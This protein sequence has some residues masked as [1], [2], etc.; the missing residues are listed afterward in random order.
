MKALDSSYCQHQV[1]F[2]YMQ[3]IDAYASCHTQLASYLKVAL[4]S[5][6]EQEALGPSQHPQMHS[7]K[8]TVLMLS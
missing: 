1:P 7:P 6:V 5:T 8:T 2:S 3:I 4:L